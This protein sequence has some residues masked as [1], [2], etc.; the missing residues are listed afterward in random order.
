MNNEV[1]NGLRL[2]RNVISQSQDEISLSVSVNVEDNPIH[3]PNEKENVENSHN[4][5]Q[6]LDKSPIA[7][8]L[9]KHWRLF[10][11][12][13]AAYSTMGITLSIVGPTLIQ[14]G[15]QVRFLVIFLDFDQLSDDHDY[16]SDSPT[17]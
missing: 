11:A 10:A 8:L 13:F 16:N 4:L 2:D 3:V 1:E 17:Q 15:R 14:L 6:T 9:G 5:Y 12:L 7:R